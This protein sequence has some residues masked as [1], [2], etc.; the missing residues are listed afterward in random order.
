MI[1]RYVVMAFCVL[2]VYGC[3][4]QQN[5]VC[6][7]VRYEPDFMTLH[8]DTLSIKCMSLPQVIPFPI[9]GDL[10]HIGDHYN[11][12]VEDAAFWRTRYVD[13]IYAYEENGMFVL[14]A[15]K[16]DVGAHYSYRMMAG[17]KK[18][19]I[20][21]NGIRILGPA[22]QLKEYF[23]KVQTE[24]GDLAEREVD[25]AAVSTVIFRDHWLSY[26]HTYTLA[27][28]SITSLRVDF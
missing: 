14:V 13:S 19:K 3:E 22:D 12:R 8:G 18:D 20:L 6:Q 28:E 24:S 9:A 15:E 1:K 16:V 5:N 26:E 23:A 4:Q 27:D 7:T 25:L 2:T 11:S 17:V 21:L 10:E